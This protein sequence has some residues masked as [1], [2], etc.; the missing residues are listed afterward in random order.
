MVRFFNGRAW[1]FTDTGATTTESLY[2]F[3]HQTFLEYDRVRIWLAPLM[4]LWSATALNAQQSSPAVPPSSYVR[5]DG[6]Q[7]AQGKSAP[8]LADLYVPKDPGLHP[9]IVY[10][11]GGGWTGDSRIGWS[12]LIAPFAEHG[13][14]GM[15][16]DYD[17]SPSV[18]FPVALEESKEA[19]RWLRAHALQYHVDPKRIAVAGG[20]AGGELAALVALTN[21]DPRYEV[22]ELKNFS[23]SVKAAVLYSADAAEITNM[24]VVLR[25]VYSA[26]IGMMIVGLTNASQPE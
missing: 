19:V 20:S 16:I 22:G 1:L 24:F 18:R 7:Y 4:L 13:Y 10:I 17:L 15:A 3:T 9:A 2:Q 14:V 8:L 26:T 21:G 12:R 6:V 5:I 11:H 25:V 23:S